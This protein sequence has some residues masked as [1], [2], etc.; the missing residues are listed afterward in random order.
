MCCLLLTTERCVI[1]TSS[2]GSYH[3]PLYHKSANESVLYTPSANIFLKFL[4]C[5]RIYFYTGIY[6]FNSRLSSVFKA[7]EP[8][9]C[10]QFFYSYTFY[11]KSTFR[12]IP[13][14]SYLS[15]LIVSSVYL[16]PHLYTLGNFLTFLLFNF[17]QCM[18]EICDPFS[19][20]QLIPSRIV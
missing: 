15:E 10:A 17:I 18:S 1:I 5:S 8:L 9:Y 11:W 12:I 3:S 16:L 4:S 14:I 7:F 6:F 19:K 20:L 13:A 2:V